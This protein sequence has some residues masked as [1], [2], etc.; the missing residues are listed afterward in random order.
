[1]GFARCPRITM[2]GRLGARH[3]ITPIRQVNDLLYKIFHRIALMQGFLRVRTGLIGTGMRD[4]S[5][6]AKAVRACGDTHD[7]PRP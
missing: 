4:R 2:C 1:M 3:A 5:M 7:E 6:C